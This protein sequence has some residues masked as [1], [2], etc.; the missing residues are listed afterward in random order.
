MRQIGRYKLLSALGAGGM[1]QVFKAI[2]NHN[3][4]LVAI[5][6]IHR[7]QAAEAREQRVHVLAQ[8]RIDVWA[9]HGLEG[10]RDP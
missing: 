6:V 7:L 9:G 2:D 1:G 8:G 5:K 3:G 10:T 4:E